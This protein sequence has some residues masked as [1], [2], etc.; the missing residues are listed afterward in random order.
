MNAFSISQLL[1]F[2]ETLWE[3]DWVYA[4]NA[5]SKKCWLMNTLPFFCRNY[6][7]F[8]YLLAGAS[9]QERESLNLSQPQD[10]FYLNQ[11]SKYSTGKIACFFCFCF[12]FEGGRGAVK[13]SIVKRLNTCLKSMWRLCKVLEE[14]I[15]HV[16]IA[17]QSIGHSSEKNDSYGVH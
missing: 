6:H 12:F 16:C 13:S 11:V 14:I 7:V 3:C 8:Y 5:R 15:F 17:I 9:E 4:I 10:F 2:N 1:L